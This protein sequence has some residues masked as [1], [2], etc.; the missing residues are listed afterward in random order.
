M[1]LTPL[2]YSPDYSK[3]MQFQFCKGEPHDTVNEAVSIERFASIS[4]RA[5]KP[6]CKLPRPHEL[7]KSAFGDSFA[8]AAGARY[9]LFLADTLAAAIGGH[10]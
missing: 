8:D 1:A 3:G 2:S 6:D 4:L 10:R 7:R 9:Q 5:G